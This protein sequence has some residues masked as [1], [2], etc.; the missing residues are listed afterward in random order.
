LDIEQADA[1]LQEL[2]DRDV[3]AWQKYWVP[4]F[5]KFARDLAVDAHLS[6]GQIV[7]DIGTGTGIAAL[8][9]LK[10]VKP[11]GI[12]LGIDR[13]GP[14]LTLAEAEH[15]NVRNV[16]FLKMNSE[17]LIFPD[18]LFDA[19]I[20]NCGISSTAFPATVAEIF[21][22]LRKG[23]SLTFN[24]WHLIDVPAHRVFSQILRRHRTDDPSKRLRGQRMALARSEHVGNRYSNPRVQAEELQRVGFGKI[25]FKKRTYKIRLPS[26]QNYLA[27]RFDREALRQELRELSKSQRAALTRELKT[28]LK[29]FMRKGRFVIEWKV[30]FT[31]AIKPR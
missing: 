1:I 6:M 20:S 17:D 3:R 11:G 4:V 2:W 26:I 27:M 18:E 23:G 13:S 31:H 29:Q 19:A 15:A 12:V 14:I 22:V 28:G 10:H 21:R 7:L 30:T 16:C 25:R 5:R 8:E 24:D 9:V